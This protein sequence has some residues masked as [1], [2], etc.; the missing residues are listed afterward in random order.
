M[1]YKW[2]KFD[3]TSM[4]DISFINLSFKVRD[5]EQYNDKDE[6]LKPNFRHPWI[7]WPGVEIQYF[8]TNDNL[9]ICGSRGKTVWYIPALSQ[10]D[11]TVLQIKKGQAL[12][13]VKHNVK[14]SLHEEF[15]RIKNE[16]KIQNH[17]A[18][19]N[20]APQVFEIV[21][22]TNCLSNQVKWFDNMVFHPQ[23][24]AYL[25]TIVEHI[26][27]ESFPEELVML[28]DNFELSGPL[29]DKIYDACDLFNILPHDIVLGNVFFSEGNVKVIDFHK[30][31]SL[32]QDS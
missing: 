27:P 2:T 25:A 4:L 31:I 20:L 13:I 11:A 22:I 28:S 29:I 10:K 16:Q 30:W 14:E 32:R 15:E 8:F 26:Y 17:F 1:K 21:G 6:P 12:K 7:N 9:D 19:I 23:N 18:Q 24:S 5:L 3:L